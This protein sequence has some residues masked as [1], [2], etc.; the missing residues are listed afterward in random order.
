MLWARG[1][2][3]RACGGH[4][5]VIEANALG[6]FYSALDAVSQ[7]QPQRLATGLREEAPL[8]N[9]DVISKSTAVRFRCA[10]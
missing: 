5:I 10:M 1:R 7:L 9:V 3:Q 8:P 6:S 2:G 4:A